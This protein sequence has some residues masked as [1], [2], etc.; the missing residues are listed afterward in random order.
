M[1]TIHKNNSWLVCAS[2]STPSIHEFSSFIIKQYLAKGVKYSVHFMCPLNQKPSQS[3]ESIISGIG[4]IESSRKKMRRG[5]PDIHRKK[6]MVVILEIRKNL[7]R[8][9]KKIFYIIGMKIDT[10]SKFYKNKHNAEPQRKPPP[11]NQSN[12]L[13]TRYMLR[14]TITLKQYL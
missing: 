6:I 4:K 3:Q 9:W 5:K 7:N 8:I 13:Y 2:C 1:H 11:I 12:I 10:L 14:C